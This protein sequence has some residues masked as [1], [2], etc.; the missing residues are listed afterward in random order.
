MMVMAFLGKTD[1]RLEAEHLFT[2]LAHLAVHQRLAI[3]DFLQPVLERVEHQ[4]VVGQIA[5]LEEFDIAMAF[6]HL[7]RIAVDAL[8]QHTGEKEVREDNDPLVAELGSVFEPGLDQRKG[9]SGIAGLGPAKAHPFPKH[10]HDLGHVRIG[11]RIRRAAPHHHEQRFMAVHIRSC[12]RDGFL[13]PFGG[14]ADHLQVNTKFAA[15]FDHHAR[16]LR[17]IGVQD[18]GNVILGMAGGKQHSRY[19]QHALDTA[20]LQRIKARMDHRVAEFEIAIFDRRIRVACLQP[21]G[22]GGEFAGCILVA[23]AMAANHDAG[24]FRQV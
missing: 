10:A 15:I 20:R 6:G 11:V 24:F 18:G 17:S 1:F 12:C 9:H 21:F 7:V 2:V 22:K 14:S 3:K 4:L 13:D 8:D 19:C 5:C 23:A 16:I